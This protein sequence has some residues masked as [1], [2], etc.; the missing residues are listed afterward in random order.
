MSEQIVTGDSLE[1]QIGNLHKED[2]VLDFAGT[3]PDQLIVDCYYRGTVDGY[4]DFGIFVNLGEHVTGLLHRSELPRRLES[5]GWEEGDT[6]YVQVTNVRDNGNVDLGWSLRNSGREFRGAYVH[7]PEDT[8]DQEEIDSRLQ[9]SDAGS[10]GSGP[11]Q[12]SGAQT[13]SDPDSEPSET[14]ASEHD[15][16]RGRSEQEAASERV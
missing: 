4:A 11:E 3:R 1:G 2:V 5:L 9:Q 16:E 10:N 15:F 14:G 13:R 8:L 6:A 7:D 12:V